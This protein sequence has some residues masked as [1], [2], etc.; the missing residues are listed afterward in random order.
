MTTRHYGKEG[1]A[2]AFLLGMSDAL[3]VR[4]GRRLARPYEFHITTFHTDRENLR[5]DM[6]KVG[7]DIE[8]GIQ[9]APKSK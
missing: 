2:R 9:R 6:N 8:A 7:R 1:T 5:A 3:I 4:F